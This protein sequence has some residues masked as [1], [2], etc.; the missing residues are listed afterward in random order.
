VERRRRQSSGSLPSFYTGI[1]ESDDE[2]SPHI[3]YCLPYDIY[4]FEQQQQQQVKQTTVNNFSSSVST[5][6]FQH[7][8]KKSS[9]PKQ[10]QP[11]PY[12][13]IFRNVYSDQLKSNLLSTYTTEKAPVCDCKPPETCEDGVCLNKIIFTECLANCACGTYVSNILSFYSEITKRWSIYIRYFSNRGMHTSPPLS[14]SLS[15]SKKQDKF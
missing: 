14:R 4:W 7:Q 11:V 3:D 8:K 13:K 15:Q 2:K 1:F 6:T 10:K 12:K 5:S 9:K